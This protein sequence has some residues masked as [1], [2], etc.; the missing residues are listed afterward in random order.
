MYLVLFGQTL[1]STNSTISKYFHLI[2]QQFYE[3]RYYIVPHFTD[4]ETET[5][6]G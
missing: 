1:C 6:R 3:D 2:L 5:Q 4:E